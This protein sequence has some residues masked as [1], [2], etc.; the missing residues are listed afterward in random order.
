MSEQNAGS[1]NDG[2][3]KDLLAPIRKLLRSRKRWTQGRMAQTKT[4]RAVD[5][6]SRS[7]VCW[8]LMGAVEK[9]YA[10]GGCFLVDHELDRR[11]RE[12]GAYHDVD[13]NDDER[14]THAEIMELLRE[15]FY[16]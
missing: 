14:R 7:A 8:C 1:S 11:A 9:F 13:F 4:G 2:A 10:G 5:G 6:N 15:P 16:G 12:R 3:R